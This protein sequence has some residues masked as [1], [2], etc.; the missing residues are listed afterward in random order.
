M[1]S[2]PVLFL[3]HRINTVEQL[4]Q[5]PPHQGVELDLRDRGERLILQHDPFGDGADF[6]TYLRQYRHGLMILNIKS[7]GIETRVLDELRQADTVRDY[8]FLDCSFPMLQRLHR[9]GERRI[10]VRFSEFEPLSQ[11]MALA[12]KVDWVWIDCFTHLPLH[13]ETHAALSPHFKLCVVSP[14]LQG[15]PYERIG[16]FAGQVAEF[17][18]QAVCTKRPDLWE[19]ALG[20]P[21]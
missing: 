2:R 17:P 4:Q 7:E 10:A 1:S 12:G 15:H 14:E 18:V 16:E 9:M 3:A 11:A 20:Q 8:F 21:S 13:R 6:S 5:V 19:Q